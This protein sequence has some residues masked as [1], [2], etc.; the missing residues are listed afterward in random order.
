MPTLEEAT[1]DSTKSELTEVIDPDGGTTT[2]EV[3]SRLLCKPQGGNDYFEDTRDKDGKLVIGAK[4][5]PWWEGT[6]LEP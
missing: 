1:V 2:A 3:H 5:E 6:V 4:V